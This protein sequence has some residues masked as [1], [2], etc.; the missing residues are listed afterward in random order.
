M[1]A[2]GCVRARIAGFAGPRFC[3][4]TIGAAEVGSFLADRRRNLLRRCG[5]QRW[6]SARL[7]RVR[8]RPGRL[9][10][11]VRRPLAGGG[12]LRWRGRLRFGARRRLRRRRRLRH[13]L[14]ITDGE[15]RQRQRR[16]GQP[17][18]DQHGRKQ[19][20]PSVFALAVFGRHVIQPTKLFAIST[21]P[22]MLGSAPARREQRYRRDPSGTNPRCS[23]PRWH[24]EHRLGVA[25]RPPPHSIHSDRPR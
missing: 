4:C 19:H 16:D 21:I 18:R 3:D 22:A 20:F 1:A 12:R 7:L 2:Q 25:D 9:R 24:G 23:R 6:L 10:R 8:I 17:G 13:L 15:R 14:G 11:N 5:R